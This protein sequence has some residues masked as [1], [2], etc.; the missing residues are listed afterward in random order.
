MGFLKDLDASL[1]GLWTEGDAEKS[2]RESASKA[3]Q[4]REEILEELEGIDIPDKERILAIQDEMARLGIPVEEYT[5]E[6][7]GPSAYEQI[8]LDPRLREAQLGV[9]SQLSEYGRGGLSALEKAQMRQAQRDLLTRD[10][11]AQR[12]ITQQM[13]QRG[14]LDSGV[15]LEARLRAASATAGDL[16]ESGSQIAL[17]SAQNRQR[18]LAGL[19]GAA[20]QLRRQDFG[21]AMQKASAKDLIKEFNIKQRN[22]GQQKRIADIEAGQRARQQAALAKAQLEQQQFQ[23]RLRKTGAASSATGNLGIQSMQMAQAQSAAS[24]AERQAKLQMGT[25]LAQLGT[26]AYSS[27]QQNKK[28]TV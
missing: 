3:R 16:G 27:N 28:E 14:T 17:Q 12:N 11:T 21:E 18:A 15:G 26:T 25:A 1:L 6:E 22:I 5:P 8:S 13:A 24:A 19:S 2:A 20:G 10:T 23:D 7:L 9:L 4:F